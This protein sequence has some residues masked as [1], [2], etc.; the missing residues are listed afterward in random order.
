MTRCAPARM[1]AQA[2]PTSPSPEYVRDPAL[3]HPE[4]VTRSARSGTSWIS[5]AYNF[6]L[7]DAPE[8]IT[9][10][11]SG[12]SALASACAAKWTN[13]NC[14]GVDD[15][16]A[17]GLASAPERTVRRD[18]G[19]CSLMPPISRAANGDEFPRL[20]YAAR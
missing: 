18:A 5:R 13:E 7:S 3:R 10:D 8:R 15:R 12:A 20:P 1:N 6:G 9:A 2:S 17:R 16:Y 19:N 14:A 4:I 11:S